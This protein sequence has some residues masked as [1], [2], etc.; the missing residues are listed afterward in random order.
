[1]VVAAGIDKSDKDLV[2][3]WRVYNQEKS[4]SG[5]HVQAFACLEGLTSKCYENE[6]ITFGNTAYPTRESLQ[7]L[8]DDFYFALIF[9]ASKGKQRLCARSFFSPSQLQL[10]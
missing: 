2:G 1:M 3:M 7:H 9:T 4:N 8:I 6:I 10:N 5:L